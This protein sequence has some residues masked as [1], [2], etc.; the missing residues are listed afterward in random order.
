M[1]QP[2]KQFRTIE[3]ISCFFVLVFFVSCDREGTGL[4]EAGGA[5]VLPQNDSHS[6]GSV[7]HVEP[8]NF[9]QTHAIHLQ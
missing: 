8:Q 3:W 7:A 6:V 9:L 2:V 4:N 5:F 1:S